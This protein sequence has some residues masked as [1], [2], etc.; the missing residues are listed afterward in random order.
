MTS[1]APVVTDD[2]EP[3]VRSVDLPATPVLVA[4]A[5]VAL[6]VLIG[7]FLLGRASAPG[8]DVATG[9]AATGGQVTDATS[10]DLLSQALGLH[11]AG[12]LAEAEQ[13]YQQIL[14]DD[15]SNKF[16]L[17]NLG[18]IA[19][20]RNDLAVAIGFYDR[21]LVVDPQMEPALYN[22]AIAL[23]DVGR[24]DESLAAFEGLL[25]SNPDSVGVLFNLGNLLIS[26]GDVVR[27]TELV[28][29]AVELEPSLRGN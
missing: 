2:S 14:S 7:I 21:A 16:A 19:Q 24:T 29:R 9:G 10:D 17:Y 5:V 27:G 25:A 13:L 8:D 3:T 18:Q 15:A 1:E 23:R 12:N 26:Q 4:A 28:N 6:A 20:T 22:R 11:S